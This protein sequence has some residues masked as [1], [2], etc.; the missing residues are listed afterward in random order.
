MNGGMQSSS[1]DRWTVLR[2]DMWLLIFDWQA[3][4]FF[5]YLSHLS[6]I[7]T[8][9][10][11]TWCCL[12]LLLQG[13]RRGAW[14][15]TRDFPSRRTWATCRAPASPRL[16]PTPVRRRILG[17][18]GMNWARQSFKVKKDFKNGR[19]FSVGPRTQVR[20]RTKRTHKSQSKSV[21]I[22]I[23]VS[24]DP[25][26]N[27]SRSKSKSV[28]IQMRWG[29]WCPYHIMKDGL[30]VLIIAHQD[31]LQR[32][33]SL[34]SFQVPKLWNPYLRRRRTTTSAPAKK[35]ENNRPRPPSSTVT[36]HFASQQSSTS[37]P[38]PHR[39]LPACR[40]PC[41]VPR[42]W[43]RVATREWCISSTGTAAGRLPRTGK[44]EPAPRPS[45]I[46]RR[47]G[48]K[49]WTR[50]SGTTLLVSLR[51]TLC[52]RPCKRMRFC[53]DPCRRHRWL[54]AIWTPFWMIL[55]KW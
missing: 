6:A 28:Q 55:W 23:Q 30:H 52:S 18:V 38:S 43:C 1:V 39:S 31:S 8:V 42:V 47:P 22:P 36:L 12:F 49:W 25:N 40:V 48:R 27:Q 32:I 19:H 5:V 53:C 51:M 17:A 2:R 34:L 9:Q 20:H 29:P 44:V 35:W 11:L 7:L 41:A 16:L 3:G 4:A 54:R 50:W 46:P 26:P 13:Y 21:Q 15:R 45:W 33:G 10:T 14:P 37:T 24:P